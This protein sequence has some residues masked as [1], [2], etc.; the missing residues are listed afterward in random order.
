MDVNV[1][2]ARKMR[3]ED[4]L[5]TR[6]PMGSFLYLRNENIRVTTVGH[7]EDMIVILDGDTKRE[8]PPG[9]DVLVL[10]RS[11]EEYVQRL[12][13]ETLRVA[14]GNGYRATAEPALVELTTSEDSVA[15]DLVYVEVTTVGRYVLMPRYRA[16]RDVNQLTNALRSAYYMR[17]GEFDTSYF[18]NVSNLDNAVNGDLGDVGPVVSVSM[19]VVSKFDN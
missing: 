6:Y 4:T 8:V 10:G 15:D 11:T 16:H 7:T 12:M 13:R 17:H 9:D 5:T 18:T 3:S 1:V 19:N 2:D 14:D